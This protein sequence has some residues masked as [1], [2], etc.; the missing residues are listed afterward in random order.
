M[1][2]SRQAPAAA[3]AAATMSPE[4]ISNMVSVSRCRARG[5]RGRDFGKALIL[6]EKSV[7]KVNASG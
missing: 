4:W 7:P 2:H 6:Q 3:R 5:G 1:L